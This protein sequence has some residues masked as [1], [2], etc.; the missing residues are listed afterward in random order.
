[1]AKR[2]RIRRTNGEAGTRITAV[3]R[4]KSVRSD[5]SR[6]NEDS[7]GLSDSIAD[8]VISTPYDLQSIAKWFEQSNILRQCV[9]A[10]V[11]NIAKMGYRAVPIRK[12]VE[13]ELA[14]VEVL[15]SFIDSPNTDESL[16]ALN[17][18]K[19]TD[20]ETYGFGYI[21]VIR[22]AKKRPSLLR[23]ARAY[24]IRLMKK[25]GKAVPV[26]TS[27][28]RG[29]QRSN[30]TEYKKFRKYVQ[31]TGGAR[32]Y[33]KEFGDPRK[34]NYETGRY[35]SSDYKVPKD[36]VATELLHHR[37]Y[38]EDSYGLPRWISQLPSILGSREAE[39][40]NL[41]YFEDN[42]VPPMILSVAG[43][44][45]TRQSFEDLNKLLK[46]Q[47]VGKD[48]QNQIILVEAIPETSGL[49]D[50]GTVKLQVDKLA[51]TRPSDGL[52]KEYDDSNISKIRSSFRLPPVVIGMSQDVTFATANVSAYLAESQVFQ[53]E[54]DTHDEMLNKGFVNH[55]NGL[56]L[57]TCKLESKG[58]NVTNP[59]QIIKTLTAVNVMGGVT[60][61]SAIDIVNETLQLTLPQFP[62]KDSE[63]WE[64]W[65]DMPMTLGQKMMLRTQQTGEGKDPA[66]QGQKTD[67]NK[68]TES[69]GATGVD[70]LAV[71][72]GKE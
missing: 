31:Q 65:M 10:M 21:E 7:T 58:P 30:I 62:E 42:T 4:V 53:P 19:V 5:I 47:G 15:E 52:F 71:Q 37:Q 9:D 60:P 26:T 14:E 28:K 40:V 56:G 72:H 3:P 39:E 33:Y 44:R 17:S 48:R 63:E 38:S 2:I 36:K 11:T 18:K 70:S 50:K 41:R 67:K 29:G 43:G 32:I 49:D 34:M 35:E 23:H 54:R 64:A 8:V 27:V 57:K 69:T 13:M 55:P 68:E 66:L 20:Y 25:T 61:R 51:D 45:L 6:Q 59:D 46:Q 12:D 24:K 16:K 22:D 1:M